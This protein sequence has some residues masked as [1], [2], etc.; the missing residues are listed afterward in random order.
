VADDFGI[1]LLGKALI[2]PLLTLR[3]KLIQHLG[4]R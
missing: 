1:E 3:Q 2:N 4:I